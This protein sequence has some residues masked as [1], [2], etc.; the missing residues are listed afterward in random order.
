MTLIL[1]AIWTV[2]YALVAISL[3]RIREDKLS[4]DEI[5]F[6]N[7]MDDIADPVTKRHL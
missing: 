4:A 2:G 3:K 1:I 6:Q 5:D 7:N